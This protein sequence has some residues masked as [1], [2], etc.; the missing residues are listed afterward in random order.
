MLA[1]RPIVVCMVAKAVGRFDRERAVVG[2]DPSG[3]KVTT[4]LELKRKASRILLEMRVRLIGELLD[5]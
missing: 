5:L 1:R 4:L 3:S 2:S